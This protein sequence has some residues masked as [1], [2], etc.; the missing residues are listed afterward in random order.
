MSLTN[1]PGIPQDRSLAGEVYQNVGAQIAMQP[2]IYASE[3]QY[4]PKYTELGVRNLRTS[5]L[6]TPDTPGLLSLY[7][8]DIY[9]T[10]ARIQAAQ[11]TAQR[12]SD[13]AA[14]EQYAPRITAA[15]NAADPGAS[16]LRSELQRQATDE[17][18]LGS[19]LSP[20]LRRELEQSAAASQAASGRAYQPASLAQRLMMQGQA[21]EALKSNRR[22]FATNML[23]ATDRSS[24]VLPVLFRQNQI[25][26]AS[27]QALMGAGGS[28]PTGSNNIQ[29]FPQYASD[30]YNTNYNARA[31]Q[32]A[33]QYNQ[34]A[35]VASGLMSMGSGMM[36]G[37]V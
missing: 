11:E 28:M 29:M 3:S 10:Q 2:Q 13:I 22:A 25:P 7:E 4:Q 9:P 16:S 34:R 18:S 31:S 15:M 26:V 32:L 21:G 27:E 33:A 8:N 17:L 1:K 5:M 12:E 35:Q 36:G 24:S 19:Q 23:A 14:L 37:I 30:L 6:G 20:S